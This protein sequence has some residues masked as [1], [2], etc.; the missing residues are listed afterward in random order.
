[1]DVAARV[2]KSAEDLP[3]PFEDF[4][5]PV[6]HINKQYPPTQKTCKIMKMGNPCLVVV[7]AI[8]IGSPDV[9]T[10]QVC[11]GGASGPSDTDIPI[12]PLPKMLSVTPYQLE[13]ADIQQGVA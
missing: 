11:S 5:R 7:L 10:G 13:C 9:I 2:T 1:V 4:D 3:K 6:Q 12:A 8:L